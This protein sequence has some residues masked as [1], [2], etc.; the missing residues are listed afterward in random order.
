MNQ[1]YYSS[2]NTDTMSDDLL[3]Y[4]HRTFKKQIS[5]VAACADE[6]FLTEFTY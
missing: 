6:V 1:F 4:T 3:D 5:V 2:F